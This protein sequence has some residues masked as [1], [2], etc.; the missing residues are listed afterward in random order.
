MDLIPS[1]R[2]SAQAERARERERGREGG[3][4]GE[5]EKEGGGEGETR[6][7]ARARAQVVDID[8]ATVRLHDGLD[9]P[10]RERVW[11]TRR[12]WTSTGRRSA[13]DL[14]ATGRRLSGRGREREMSRWWTSTGRRLYILVYNRCIES[15]RGAQVYR[16]RER[17]REMSRW[18]TSTGRRSGS[19]S[20]APAARAPGTPRTRV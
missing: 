16:E 7:P 19:S 12:W 10:D 5:R 8:G 18:W 9:T 6:A 20:R 3:R 4:E 11:W 1:T 2:S 14:V 17:E 13:T 15:F